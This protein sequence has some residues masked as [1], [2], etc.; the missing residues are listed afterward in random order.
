M[1]KFDIIT[2]ADARVLERGTHRGARA[3]RPHH[4]A[5]PRYAPR[6]ADYGGRGGPGVGRRSLAGSPRRHPVAGDRQRPFGGVALRRTLVAF[7]RG[8]GP[9]GS[10]S[11]RGRFRSRGVIRT[12][13][14][15]SPTASPAAKPTPASSS[16]RRIGSGDRREQDSGDPGRDGQLGNDRP[17][18]RASR[19]ARTC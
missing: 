16:T 9:G 18:C 19:P 10:G 1:K 4:A 17:A 11:G 8:R 6:T 2:E 12:W 13:R 15:A 3:W 7:L 5:G 14:R